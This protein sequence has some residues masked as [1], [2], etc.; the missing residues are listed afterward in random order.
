MP[1][2]VHLIALRDPDAPQETMEQWHLRL[3]ED[4]PAAAK[5]WAHDT[6][7]ARKVRAFQHPC[8]RL[9]HVPLSARDAMSGLCPC[10]TAAVV[11]PYKLCASL[12]AVLLQWWG[13]VGMWAPPDLEPEDEEEGAAPPS[14]GMR[15]PATEFEEVCPS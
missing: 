15:A 14:S 9:G 1:D 12:Q 11:T 2:N 13:N 3:G 5:H 7:A 6:A 10:C 4:V 8:V